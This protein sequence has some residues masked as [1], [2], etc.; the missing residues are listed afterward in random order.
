M[1]VKISSAAGSLRG[2]AAQLAPSH[3]DPQEHAFPMHTWKKQMPIATWSI[4]GK[5]A[6]RAKTLFKAV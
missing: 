4:S 3:A 5:L 6:Y 1:V 2:D